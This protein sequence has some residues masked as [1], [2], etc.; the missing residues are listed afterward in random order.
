MC[1]GIE[2]S[3]LETH[4]LFDHIT[5][6]SVTAVAGG[7][8]VGE[9]LDFDGGV[10]RTALHACE[11]HHRV[12]GNVVAHHKDL[13][14]LQPV[15]FEILVVD[16]DFVADMEEKFHTVEL[17]EPQFHGFSIAPGDD[18]HF[19][20][21]LESVVQR[22]AVFDVSGA[23]LLAIG[24]HIDHPVGEHPVEIEDEGTDFV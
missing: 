18:S 5:D 15:V 21:F 11:L 12:V 3:P 14:G 17:P 4:G 10:C 9:L 23:Y 6:G 8:V 19:V 7:D 20:A 13:F 24:R 22:I 16:F 2:P 1:V